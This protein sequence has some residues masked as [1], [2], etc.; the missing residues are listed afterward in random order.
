MS[1]VLQNPIIQRYINYIGDS[2]ARAALGAL[3]GRFLLSGDMRYVSWAEGTSVP[4]SAQAGYSP[5]CK[6]ILSN[7]ALGQCSEW[8]NIGSATSCLFVPSGPVLGYGFA[9]AGGPITSAGGDVTEVITIGSGNVSA[10]D[11]PILGMETTNDTDQVDVVALASAGT[12]TITANAD[13]GTAHSYV[14]GL[15]RSKCLPSWDIVA[16]GTRVAV[17][18]DDATIEIAVTGVLATDIA[19]GSVVDTDDSDLLCGVVPGAGTVTITMSA[20]PVTEHTFGYVVLRPRGSFKPSHYIAY[21]G[22]HT[23]VAD[24]GAP[25]VNTIT[26]TGAL[27]TDI[28]IV[29]WGSAGAGADIIEAVCSADALT[30]SFGA[31]PTVSKVVNYMIVRAY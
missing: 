30:V 25:H 7:A 16:A 8:T 31:D 27:A 21:A 24:V 11:I 20:D 23:T 6:F 28:P 4:A 14:Y 19:F 26:V 3:F 5:G 13:P 10:A 15:L 1:R 17:A 9:T 29:C 18:G 12:I 2:R 22:T